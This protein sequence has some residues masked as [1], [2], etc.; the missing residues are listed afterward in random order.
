MAKRC[1]D[2]AHC[3]IEHHANQM[4]DYCTLTHREGAFDSPVSENWICDEWERN[5]SYNRGWGSIDPYESGE[6]KEER[7]K[8]Q[9]FA[10]AQRLKQDCPFPPEPENDRIVTENVIKMWPRLRPNLSPSIIKTLGK[11]LCDAMWR[12]L[13]LGV[14]HADTDDNC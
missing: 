2:C 7:E 11:V 8:L 4:S 10:A 5:P 3:R 13:G 9:A 12:Y 1:H 14:K 6:A